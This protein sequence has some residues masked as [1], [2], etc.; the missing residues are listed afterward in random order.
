MA[1]KKGSKKLNKLLGKLNDLDRKLYDENKH[2]TK[3][4]FI[5][6]KLTGNIRMYYDG[7]SPHRK[8]QFIQFLTKEEEWEA[9][10]HLRTP[11]EPE[12]PVTV[13]Q[14]LTSK[15]AKSLAGLRRD[16]KETKKKSKKLTKLREKKGKLSSMME[17]GSY[18]QVHLSKKDHRKLISQMADKDRSSLPSN[19]YDGGIEEFKEALRGIKAGSNDIT[20]SFWNKHGF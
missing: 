13:D 6:S 4:E 17:Y 8:E 1:K 18:D 5:E 14:P 20:E 11:D 7:L 19:R 2:V 12:G 10:Q 16:I 15:P 9:H 3:G